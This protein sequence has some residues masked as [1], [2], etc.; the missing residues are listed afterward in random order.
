MCYVM[1]GEAHTDMAKTQAEIQKAYRDRLKAKAQAQGDRAAIFIK[2]GFSKRAERHGGF[3][4]FESALE[5]AGIVPPTFFDERNASKFILNPD[6]NGT[7]IEALLP[8]SPSGALGRAEVIID[9]LITAAIEL[10]AEVNAHK[11]SEIKARLA[12]LETSDTTDRATA[13]Q[14]AVKLNK[15]LD[16]L[17]K[18]VRRSFPQWKVTGI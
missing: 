17:N 18:Q 5:V 7:D 6:A 1:E 2:E 13:M 10:A 11:T 16:Q 8:G 4:D 12:D 3:S 14:E 9:H 15:I